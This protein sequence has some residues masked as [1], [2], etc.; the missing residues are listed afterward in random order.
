M[1]RALW[2]AETTSKALVSRSPARGHEP[3]PAGCSAPSAFSM[4]PLIIIFPPAKFPR[5]ISG[6][7]LQRGPLSQCSR[8]SQGRAASSRACSLGLGAKLVTLRDTP[9]AI[10]GGVAIGVFIDAVA[11]ERT[12]HFGGAFEDRYWPL[13]CTCAVNGISASYSGTSKVSG[14]F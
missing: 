13:L 7:S 1:P 3:E 14:S 2:L 10:A 8:G 5:K 9:H 11:D 6:D 12:T 4:K